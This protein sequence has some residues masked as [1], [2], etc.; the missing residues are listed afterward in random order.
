MTIYLVL[1]VI[2]VRPDYEIVVESLDIGL[3]AHIANI[4][5]FLVHKFL[6][7]SSIIF[8]IRLLRIFTDLTSVVLYRGCLSPGVCLSFDLFLF[9]ACK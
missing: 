6:E 5:S 1:M 3:H 7:S 9:L 2:L 8:H 4:S